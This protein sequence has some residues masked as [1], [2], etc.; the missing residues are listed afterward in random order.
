[1]KKSIIFTLLLS[2]LFFGCSTKRQYFDPGDDNI[3]GEMAF[4]GSLPAEIIYAAKEGA[5]LSNGA[6]I[7]KS[8]VNENIKLNKNERFLGEYNGNFIATDTN[9]TTRVLGSDGSVKFERDL[10]RYALS[11]A[12]DGDDLALVMSDNSVMLF[13]LSSGAMVLD[14]KIG[15]A[16]A[17]DSRTAAPLFINQLVAYPA[18][19]GLVNIVERTGGR[20]VRDF[21]VSNQPFFNNITTLQARGDDLY[22]GTGTRLVLISPNGNKTYNRD[23]RNVLFDGDKIYLLLKDGT[24]ELLD[25][26]LNLIK[27]RK[28][29]FAQLLEGVFSGEYLYIVERTGFVIR[30]DKNLQSEAIF[31]LNDE[32]DSRAFSANSSFYYDDKVLNFAK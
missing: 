1:M 22:A 30:T 18:L 8:G 6:V 21:V 27:S 5:T 24:V 15:D 10:K 4:N 25:K 7:T 31:E 20:S 17:I 13:R 29:T 9:G 26:N 2:F 16:F 23:I 28:F 11:G 3:T 12:I 19:D 32:I 14:D